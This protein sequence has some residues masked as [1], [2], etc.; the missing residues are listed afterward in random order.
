VEDAH[1]QRDAVEAVRK[2]LENVD[3]DLLRLMLTDEPHVEA[4]VRQIQDAI[5][6]ALALDRLT[7]AQRE[8][9]LLGAMLQDE[10]RQLV[11]NLVAKLWPRSDDQ[12]ASAP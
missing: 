7:D 9:L 8:A 12:Q 4:K 5:Q 6:L 11:G 10:R 1:K 3:N 2:K